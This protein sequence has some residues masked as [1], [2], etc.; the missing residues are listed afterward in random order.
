MKDL[1]QTAKTLRLIAVMAVAGAVIAPN[2]VPAALTTTRAGGMPKYWFDAMLWL[3]DNT[4]Q[5]FGDAGYYY[6]RYGHENPPA[7]FTIMNWWDQ[8]Y[9][10]VQTAHRV[11][12]SNPTQ[13]AAPVAAP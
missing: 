5:P 4:P 6:A 8:G 13:S 11:P 12:V 7:A 9:W 2:L 10:I 3:R 1:S